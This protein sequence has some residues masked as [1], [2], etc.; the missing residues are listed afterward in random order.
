MSP[1]C[2]NLAVE[3]YQAE[4][5][6][7]CEQMSAMTTGDSLSI[8]QDTDP[9]ADKESPNLVAPVNATIMV[10]WKKYMST[11]VRESRKDQKNILEWWKLNQNEFPY[12]SQVARSILGSVQAAV[13]VEVD[14]GMTGMYIPK[15]RV[16]T[17][18][19]MVEMKFF[20]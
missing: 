11:K 9:R 7:I 18:P 12:L 13:A 3:A 1:R 4:N 17:S 15:N 16:S 8:G 5:L 19:E 20:T 6:E 14:N 10:E 2:F